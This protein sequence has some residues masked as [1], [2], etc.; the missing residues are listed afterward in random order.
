MGR[1]GNRLVLVVL[2]AA[3]AAGLL[4]S[5]LVRPQSKLT[6]AQE[7]Y[8]TCRSATALFLSSVFV[9]YGREEDEHFEVMVNADA[10][11]SGIP[12]GQVVVESGSRVLCTIHLHSGRGMCSLTAKELT[13]GLHDIVAHFTGTNGFTSSRSRE[14]TLIVLRHP[15]FEGPGGNGLGGHQPP[16][17]PIFTAP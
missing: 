10:R 7:C 8:G 13:P 5:V 2:A 17:D 4:T 11:G 9:V 14:V 6:A 12:A 15:F 3:L 16:G 1:A